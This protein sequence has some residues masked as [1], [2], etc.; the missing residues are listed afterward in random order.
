VR[1]VRKPA[2]VLAA[3]LALGGAP[4]AYADIDYSKNSVSGEYAPAVP[5][6]PA[7]ASAASDPS[8][9]W[10]DAAIGAGAALSV[11]LAA[12]LARIPARRVFG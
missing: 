6:A 1:S 8:F 5:A 11:V 3:V 4:V 12:G 9:E 2:A 7:P 10:D